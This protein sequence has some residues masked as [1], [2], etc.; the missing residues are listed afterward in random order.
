MR[1]DEINE[2]YI[3]EKYNLDNE[4]TTIRLLKRTA[5]LTDVIDIGLEETT[6]ETII[7]NLQVHL[8]SEK[9]RYKISDQVLVKVVWPDEGD[10]QLLT[11]QMKPE[12]DSMVIR[13]LISKERSIL[14]S[15]QQTQREREE[16]ERKERELYRKLKL[17]Y[18][19]ANANS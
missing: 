12:S 11:Y 14:R 18:G 7:S 16:I 8:D 1:I 3:R 17:K 13:R 2:A 15:L 5:Y 10:I 6:L 19:G 4:R 9:T